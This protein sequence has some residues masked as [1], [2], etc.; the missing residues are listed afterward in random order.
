MS[1]QTA[2]PS[3]NEVQVEQTWD[4]ASI[5][6][7]PADWDAACN[8]LSTLMP[9]LSVYRGH[10]GENPL[11]LLQF[12]HLLQEAGTLMGKIG[13]YASN[14]YS[15]NTLDQDAAARNGQARSLSAKFSAAIAF[16]DPE[17]MKIG[18]PKLR[19]WMQEN[20]RLAF[21]AHYVDKLERRQAHVRSD[22]VEEV[23]ALV[24]DP[25]SSASGIYSTLNNAELTFQPAVASDG[26]QMEVG[27][28]SIGALVTHPD[29]EVRRTAWDNYADG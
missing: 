8:Q 4:L 5:F 11:T 15:V 26:T 21:F 17:L 9:E 24:N 29:R 20:P 7:T 19:Q 18:F 14:A 16:F 6:S 28:A 2:L 25:F 27:Q 10:L 13:V 1:N 3:R 23:M 22:D 12:I